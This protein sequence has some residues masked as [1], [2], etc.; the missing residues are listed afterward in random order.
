M[1]WTIFYLRI[2]FKY[3]INCLHLCIPWVFF[4]FKDYGYQESCRPLKSI[5]F[6]R[7]CQVNKGIQCL[8]L[9]LKKVFTFI[10]DKKKRPTKSPRK[11][12]ST[13]RNNLKLRWVQEQIWVSELRVIKSLALNEFSCGPQMILS[14]KRQLNICLTFYCY[15]WSKASKCKITHFRSKFTFLEFTLL[16]NMIHLPIGF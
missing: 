4:S 13:K 12:Y 5:L 11:G 14:F 15:T 6:I 9:D 7:S 3:S 1:K 16:T 2:I 8:E 10:V